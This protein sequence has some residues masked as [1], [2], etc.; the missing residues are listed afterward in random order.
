MPGKRGKSTTRRPQYSQHQRGAARSA[1]TP[2]RMSSPAANCAPELAG[3]QEQYHIREHPSRG[4]QHVAA[5]RRRKATTATNGSSHAKE[6]M[7]PWLHAEDA[8]A[9]PGCCVSARARAARHNKAR[10]TLAPTASAETA[11]AAQRR[12]G[13]RSRARPQPPACPGSSSS[14]F[15]RDCPTAG[16]RRHG[17]RWES[18]ALAA[19]VRGDQLLYGQVIAAGLEHRR[20][21]LVKTHAAPSYPNAPCPKVN[22]PPRLPSRGSHELC[23]SKTA[24]GRAKSPPGCRRRTNLC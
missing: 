23:D 4:N 3:T 11:V 10:S 16:I 20:I 13:S 7:R 18:S 5:H 9:H 8:L 6:S 14:R 22:I 21:P 19:G 17:R 24:P 12:S 15:R 1:A 2:A